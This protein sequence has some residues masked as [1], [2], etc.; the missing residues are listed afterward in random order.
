MKRVLICFICGGLLAMSA[1]APSF[2][3]SYVVIGKVE[4]EAAQTQ[5]NFMA[6]L[7]SLFADCNDIVVAT[8][9]EIDNSGATLDVLLGLYGDLTPGT[10]CVAMTADGPVPIVGA[11]YLLFLK[12][13]QGMTQMLT[14]DFG[15]LRIEDDTILPYA[16]GGFTLLEQAKQDINKLKNNVILPPN[17]YYYQDIDQLVNACDSIFT[18]TVSAILPSYK[19]NFFSRMGGVETTNTQE[20]TPIRINAE[21]VF[22]GDVSQEVNI[23]LTSTMLSSTL[24]AATL[25]PPAYNQNDMPPF[26]E[27][28]DYLFFVTN[29]PSGDDSRY[30]Y[31]VNPFQGYV[32][33]FEQSQLMSIPTNAVFSYPMSLQD[34]VSDIDA[35]A[36]GE[37][38]LNIDPIG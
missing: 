36:Q 2:D 28:G 24:V 11:T 13:K 31:F 20:A 25:Q 32:P 27:G 3:E 4:A 30:K 15:Y 7:Y 12:D 21:Q 37:G 38:I 5:Y 34:V 16:G 33:I 9:E 23:V 10:D 29:A 14:D 6:T 22:K 26:E 18:G 19:E 1:C 17:F 8:V 35:I